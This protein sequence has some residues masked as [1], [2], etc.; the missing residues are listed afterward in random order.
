MMRRRR[1]HRAVGGKTTST[2]LRRRRRRS[3]VQSAGRPRVPGGGGD[4]CCQ[5]WVVS[6]LDAHLHIKDVG[7]QCCDGV[8]SVT[9]SG[10]NNP[11]RMP[12]DHT[13]GSVSSGA[14]V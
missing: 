13:Y 7:L 1:S 4:C 10:K 9:L 6:F 11:R 5:S 3:T 8:Y 12:L 14:K 2:R